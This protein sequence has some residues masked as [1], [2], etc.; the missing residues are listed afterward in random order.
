MIVQR[1]SSTTAKLS[2]T[3]GTQMSQ[4][5][6]E[7]EDVVDSTKT[8]DTLPLLLYLIINAAFFTIFFSVVYYLLVRWREKIRHSDPLHVVTVYEIAAIVSFVA[9]FIY[10]FN[11]FGIGIIQPF[12][13][14]HVLDEETEP[15]MG[16]DTIAIKYQIS[17]P[18]KPVCTNKVKQND[19]NEVI[20]KKFMV[21]LSD[22]DKKGQLGILTPPIFVA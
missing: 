9:S 14:P 18:M 13:S 10:L 19:I 22:E 17:D 4:G 15:S 16:L 6:H 3:R 1:R 2:T 20:Y 11:F 21:T 7:R 5:G 8:T 12:V